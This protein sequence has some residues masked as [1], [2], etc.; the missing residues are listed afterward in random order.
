MVWQ[1]SRGLV[2]ALFNQAGRPKV[3]ES[4]SRP[5]SLQDLGDRF[6][7]SFLQ[8]ERG[9]PSP[10]QSRSLKPR[11]LGST[12]CA[13]RNAISLQVGVKHAVERTMHLNLWPVRSHRE[14]GPP[15]NL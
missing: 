14:V 6:Q 10:A 7:D 3:V 12:V 13:W 2:V 5:K 11:Q 15:R 8:E 4:F 9:K 1:T